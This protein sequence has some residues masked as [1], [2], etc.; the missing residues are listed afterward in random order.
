[1]D[2]SPPTLEQAAGA[3]LLAAVVAAAIYWAAAVRCSRRS[4]SPQANLRTLR[5]FELQEV[6]K[7][8]VCP[9]DIF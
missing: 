7:D 2:I 9:G 1:M 3:C 5:E 8:E 4:K 6:L